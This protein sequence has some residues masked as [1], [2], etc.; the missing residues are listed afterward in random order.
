MNKKIEEVAKEW[1]VLSKK[2]RRY[3]ERYLRD[4][5]KKNNN[6]IDWEDIELPE[7]VSVAYDGGNHPEYASNVFSTVYG[8]KLDEDE[9]ITLHLEDCDEYQLQNVS[10]NELYTL[11]D[12]LDQYKQ[13]IGI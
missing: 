10:V 11:C 9:N 7:Y 13:K 4:L 5:L 8:V 2:L 1:N 3:C 6:Q 12:F